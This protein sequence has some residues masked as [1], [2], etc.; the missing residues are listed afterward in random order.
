MASLRALLRKLA[1][2][3]KL[4]VFCQTGLGLGRAQDDDQDKEGCAN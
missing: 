3:P 2:I 4:A 1:V